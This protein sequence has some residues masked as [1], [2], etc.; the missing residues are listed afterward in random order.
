[1]WPVKFKELKQQDGIASMQHVAHKF[2]RCAHDKHDKD[3]RIIHFNK[4]SHLP[5]AVRGTK[6]NQRA[7]VIVLD[8]LSCKQC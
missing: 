2:R 3:M 7:F 5:E 8:V 1:M 4:T 6:I